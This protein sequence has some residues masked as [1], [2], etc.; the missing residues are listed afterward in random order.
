VCIGIPQ[1]CCYYSARNYSDQKTS[2]F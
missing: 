2:H 1:I